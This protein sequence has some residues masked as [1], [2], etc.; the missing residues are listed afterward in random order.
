[1]LKLLFPHDSFDNSP[2]Q[3]LAKDAIPKPVP[4]RRPNSP[5]AKP[6]SMSREKGESKSKLDDYADIFEEFERGIMRSVSSALE[7]NAL[8]QKGWNFSPKR[9]RDIKVP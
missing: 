7:L 4:C 1:M 6:E 9:T 2:S 3:I 5:E 8:I